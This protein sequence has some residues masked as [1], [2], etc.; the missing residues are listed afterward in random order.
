MAAAATAIMSAPPSSAPDTKAALKAAATCGPQVVKHRPAP[1]TDLKTPLSAQSIQSPLSTS[2]PTWMRRDAA[3]SGSMKTP[4]T[5]PSAYLDFLKAM[6]PGMA[7]PLSTGASSHFTFTASARSPAYPPPKSASFT[8]GPG[9]LSARPTL[10]SQPSNTSV[11]SA[12][13]AASAATTDSTLTTTSAPAASNPANSSRRVERV[14]PVPPSPALP[15]R[16]A[17]AATTTG[18]FPTP[19]RPGPP[20]RRPSV[21]IPES[22]S[23][24]TFSPATLSGSYTPISAIRSPAGKGTTSPV[25]VRHVVTRTITYTRRGHPASAYPAT[26]HPA[27]I[28]SSESPAPASSSPKGKERARATSQ[29]LVG[30]AP[31][32][33]KRRVE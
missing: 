24:S 27:S 1:F 19:A 6:S 8:A 13:S 22:P 20:P 12:S 17:T 2:T 32:G 7:S 33:K 5:P 21:I 28:A 16:P 23:S 18:C 9:P 3:P 26:A 31:K 10:P 29:P 11:T 4:V 25:V 30:E 15:P 14:V